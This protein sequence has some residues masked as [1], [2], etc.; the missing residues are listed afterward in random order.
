MSRETI[1]ALFVFFIISMAV[2]KW[3]S[4][5]VIKQYLCLYWK[6]YKSLPT[7]I[8]H[9]NCGRMASPPDCIKLNISKMHQHLG[10]GERITEFEER[11]P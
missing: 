4:L 2:F 5:T 10:A 11:S 6:V 1:V 9:S 8:P 3:K 7:S